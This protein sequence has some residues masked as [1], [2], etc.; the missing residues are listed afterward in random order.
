M[1]ADVDLDEPD[2]RRVHVSEVARGLG[3]IASV[4]LVAHGADPRIAGVAHVAVPR[5]GGAGRIAA[6]TLVTARTLM[7]RRRRASAVYLRH[8]PG[9]VPVALLA[10]LLRYRLVLEVNA[11][12]VDLQ[13]DAPRGLGGRLKAAVKAVGD[14]RAV[15]AAHAVVVVSAELRDSVAA[16]RRDGAR[17]VHV[18]P[19]GA[20]TRT[21]HPMDAAAAAGRAGL[22]PSAEHVVFTG[23]LTWWMDLA[24]LV[25]AFAQ[26]HAERPATRLVIVG[27]GPERPAVE[28]R[29]AGLPVVLT[30]ALADRARVADHVAAARVCVAPADPRLRTARSPLKVLEYLASGRPVVASDVAGNR[31]PIDLTGGG[32]LVPPDD[33]RAMASAILALL[34]DPERAERIGA[35]AAAIVAADHSWM[36]VCD[37]LQ[38]L[39]G[40]RDARARRSD[41]ARP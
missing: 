41:A 34:A 8:D 18:I 30:G 7:L 12:S 15:R 35:E 19:N 20:D 29:A 26:V 11:I 33:P 24:T 37:R 23:T 10:R 36:S 38:P 3:A 4:D 40:I 13:R 22:D 1:A 28:Q 31:D 39:L 21:F 9:T 6:L 17:A 25:D 32:V 16:L 27:D 5:W 2:G 14:R